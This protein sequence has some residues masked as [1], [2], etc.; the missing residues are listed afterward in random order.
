[1]NTL[2]LTAIT[3]S[4]LYLIGVLLTS[5]YLIERIIPTPN[6]NAYKPAN[7]D[8]FFKRYKEA[9]KQQMMFLLIWPFTV[10]IWIYHVDITWN[11]RL[12]QYAIYWALAGIV[13][14]GIAGYGLFILAFVWAA[15]RMLRVSA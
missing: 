15:N 1:M 8:L 4:S 10:M 6:M 7:Y 3:A 13:L 5:R 9:E 14:A 2:Q 11:F 12:I